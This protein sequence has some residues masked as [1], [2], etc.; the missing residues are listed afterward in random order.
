M[1][2]PRLLLPALLLAAYLRQA[3][4]FLVCPGAR[5][6]SAGALH[7]GRGRP[8][9]R[10]SAA[11]VRPQGRAC[12]L[13]ASM[14]GAASWEQMVDRVI[15][16]LNKGMAK[17]IF[18]RSVDPETAA[19]LRAAVLVAGRG[20][21]RRSAPQEGTP[22]PSLQ[23]VVFAVHSIVK[24]AVVDREE[25][26]PAEEWDKIAMGFGQASAIVNDEGEERPPNAPPLSLDDIVVQ[27]ERMFPNASPAERE[28]AARR[29][30][31]LEAAT[32]LIM[33]SAIS[34]TRL[35]A[36][37]PT[38][39]RGARKAPAEPVQANGE[40]VFLTKGVNGGA[41]AFGLYFDVSAT[42]YPLRITE[43][44]SCSSAGLNFG[45]GKPVAVK[46]SLCASGS[47]R[48]RETDVSAWRVVGSDN[49][50]SLPIVTWFDETASYA[51]LPLDAPI[52]LEAGQ[53]VGLCIHTSDVHGLAIRM[54]RT[55]AGI[56]SDMTDDEFGGNAED[57]EVAGPLP[58]PAPSACF[59]QQP[60]LP[61]LRLIHTVASPRFL[62]LPRAA[63]SFLTDTSP[64]LRAGPVAR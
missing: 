27:L 1:G 18:V 58:L 48:G 21:K 22:A 34:L 35:S 52:D 31:T 15:D 49:R 45:E 47:G 42:D 28:E 54:A 36:K 62:S 44:R 16:D 59:L 6:G 30:L 5:S 39:A 56:D 46:V 2:S 37:P 17:Y 12:A 9:A 25:L 11:T 26:V 10:P 61:N 53:T 7:P 40:G 33:T 24:D 51:P 20:Y 63:L 57:D 13:R 8:D 50:L 4:A 23:E 29:G 60:R 38:P 19:E 32:D 3:P 55:Q 41:S 43:I 64:T 14:S